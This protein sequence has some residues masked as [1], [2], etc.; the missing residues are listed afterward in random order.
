[1]VE[2]PASYLVRMEDGELQRRHVDQILA[3]P[4]RVEPSQHPR[5]SR[6]EES[7]EDDLTP[8][9]IPPPELWPDIIGIPNTD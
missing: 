1:M 5:D 3:R 4:N 9:I 7:S 8:I 2:G 6:A